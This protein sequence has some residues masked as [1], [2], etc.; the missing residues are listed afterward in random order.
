MQTT[1]DVNCEMLVDQRCSAYMYIYI[2]IYI[3]IVYFYRLQFISKSMFTMDRYTVLDRRTVF[4]Q[5]TYVG[6]EGLSEQI[7][8][9]GSHLNINDDRW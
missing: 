3:Y 5:R 1:L 2:Y 8:N 6:K 7:S 9:N 4:E